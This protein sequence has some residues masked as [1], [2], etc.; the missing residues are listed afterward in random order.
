MGGR[1]EGVHYRGIFRKEIKL[2]KI[3]APST[4]FLNLFLHNFSIV[5]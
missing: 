5:E 2:E 1:A 3:R 4:Q